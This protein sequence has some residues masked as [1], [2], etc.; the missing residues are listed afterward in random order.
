MT[1]KQLQ[2]AKRLLRQAFNLLQEVETLME[3]S[4]DKARL[5]VLLESILDEA[6]YV[7]SLLDN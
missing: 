4:T 3:Q 1:R 2:K 6:E 5:N 7:Q